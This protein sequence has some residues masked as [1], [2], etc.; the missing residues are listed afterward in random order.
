MR[1][2][3]IGDEDINKTRNSSASSMANSQM[4]NDETVAVHEEIVVAKKP[5]C[6]NMTP[7]ILML[8]LSVH[9]AFEGLALG[10]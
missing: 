3:I 8:A 6:C 7:Y 1:L 5:R 9:A 2:I 10:L 4:N